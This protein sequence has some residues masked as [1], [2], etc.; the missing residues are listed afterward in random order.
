[1]SDKCLHAP[2]ELA[3]D[4]SAVSQA[5]A[6]VRVLKNLWWLLIG[7]VFRLAI[8]IPLAGF[9]AYHLG[10]EGYG[11]LNL[12]L[13]LVVL[14][15]VLANL[16]LNE[17]LTR[18]VAQRPEETQALWTSVLT[19]KVGLLSVYVAILVGVGW[20]LGYSE[21]VLWM[22][23]LL[24][25]AQWVLS[26]E[27]ASRA[28]FAGRQQMGVLGGADFAKVAIESMLWFSVLALGYGAI[29]LAGVRVVI[30]VFGFVWVTVMLAKRLQIRLA[31][32]CWRQAT[33]LLPAG[34][35]FATT[36]ALLS[37]YERIGIVLLVHLV[38]PQ[39]VALVSTATTLTEK[40]FWFV[41]SM[42]GAVFPF[43][44]RLHV[45]ERDR[46]GSAFARALR[47]QVLIAVGCGLG[48]SLLGPWL[49]RV[50]FP[51]EFWTAGMVVEVLG[52]TCAPKLVSSLFVTVLQS[53]SR[54]RQVSWISAIQCVVY[55][56]ATF[57]CVSAWGVSGFAWAYLLAE[58][59]A[60]GL[61]VGCLWRTGAF[62]ESDVGVLT[63]IL[64]CGVALFFATALFP[65]GRENFF[66]V[67]GVL[68][69][70]PA[71][72]VISRGVSRE[73]IRYLQGLWLSRRPSVA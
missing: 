60:V 64:S 69:C 14:L 20:L 17:V 12:A 34:C 1:M 55:I 70:F 59:V 3:G 9:T 40:I 31:W 73:D 68:L 26:L 67:V 45:T 33:T 58:S 30:A 21:D 36:S 38:G 22:V 5:N 61:Y 44:S 39:A 15:G 10:L 41:P 7:P 23:L 62:A 66:V 28:V 35:R 65:G 42:Q 24:G 43:F 54:E 25:V 4:R 47:Y 29:T 48:A 6:S 18:T 72:L 11:E 13:S 46:F 71:L 56:I 57:F 37:I 8:G 19:F 52:W 51:E 50:V 16:G 32:P 27:N 63:S 49:I 53:L 2:Q